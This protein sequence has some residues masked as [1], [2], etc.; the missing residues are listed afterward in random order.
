MTG[1][2]ATGRF[3][4]GATWCAA[5][6]KDLAERL[7]DFIHPTTALVCIGNDLRGDDGAGPTVAERLGGKVPWRLYDARTA[8]ESFPVKIAVSRPASVVVIDALD[9]GAPPGTVT[10]LGA[11]RLAGIGPSTHGPSPLTFL[12]A[13][14]ML[15]PCPAVLVG[16]Q[17][18]RTDFGLPLSDAVR[19]AASRIV[20]GFRI[21][22][23]RAA[24][25]AEAAGP[26]ST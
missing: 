12:T 22:A 7:A 11:D 5:S 6:A 25:P 8:P 19:S 2:E 9:F 18:G 13:L 20:D 21:L 4:P 1:P 16:I 14:K 26:P 15:H 10:V 24:C 17:P 23:K 3:M